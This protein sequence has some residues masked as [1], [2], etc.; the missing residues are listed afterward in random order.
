MDEALRGNL[1]ETIR[2]RDV[3]SEEIGYHLYLYLIAD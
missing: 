3:G 2:L 1:I